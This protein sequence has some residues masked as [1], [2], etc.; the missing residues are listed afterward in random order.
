MAT[1][2]THIAANK[3]RSWFLLLI[4]LAVVGCIGYALDR[5]YV[6]GGYF[7]V[8][9][10][11]IYSAVSGL[12]G[13]YAG[14][15]IALRMSGA[16]PIAKDENPYVYRIVENLCIT[17][18]LPVPKIYIIPDPD[19]N[20]F[21]TGRDPEHASI[22][23]TEGA[24][25]KLENEELEGV[26]AHELSHIGNYDIRYMTLVIILVGTIIILS[27]L[28]WRLAFFGGR[29][30]K[31]GGSPAIFIGLGLLLLAAIFAPLIKF[32]VSRKREYLADASGSLLT[33]YPEGLARA[34][35]KIRE[36]GSTIERANKS[37]AHLYIANPLK[38]GI[39][40]LFSTH[41]PI[42]ERISILR[43]M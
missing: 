2:Y 31:S 28:F 10:A 4:T 16:N 39:F 24:I 15:K 12:V 27:D 33:R 21:A 22:A 36:Q 17:A 38:K 14:D 42:E 41:P 34:L 9:I 23:V 5:Y 35:E 19:I 3:R 25:Q 30:R 37:T 1:I 7:F 32:A 29:G 13:Y 43:S 40:N 6:E 20:A 18:G 11:T 26:L 8:A